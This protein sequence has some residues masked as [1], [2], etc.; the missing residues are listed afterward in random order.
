ML[1]ECPVRIFFLKGEVLENIWISLKSVMVFFLHLIS[2]HPV[3]YLRNVASMQT[4]FLL[5]YVNKH[6]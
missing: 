6:D 3:E 2:Y 5:G 1:H 4:S